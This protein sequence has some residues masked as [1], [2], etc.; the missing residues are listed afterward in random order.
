MAENVVFLYIDAAEIDKPFTLQSSEEKNL[1]IF[2]QNVAFLIYLKRVKITSMCE[3]ESPYMHISKIYLVSSNADFLP[4]TGVAQ[5]HIEKRKNKDY[6][7]LLDY[8][9]S[10]EIIVINLIS[11][12]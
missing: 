6:H 1:G 9:L 10:F 2:D 4:W 7:T 5:M 12:T 8:L 3:I 11:E